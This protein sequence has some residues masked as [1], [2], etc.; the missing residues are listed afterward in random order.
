MLYDIEYKNI[1]THLWT[2]KRPG[3]PYTKEKVLE[4]YLANKAGY[5]GG[6]Y[7]VV[8]RTLIEIV[9]VVAATLEFREIV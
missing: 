4:H 7:R 2:R 6:F 5:S 3:Y 1:Q 9:P 8:Q